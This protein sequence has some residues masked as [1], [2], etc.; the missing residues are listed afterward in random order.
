MILRPYQQDLF[1]EIQTELRSGV[2]APL[3]VS[4]TGSGKTA[5][6]CYIAHRAS[7][8]N[9]DVLILV[10]RAELIIQTSETLAR[11]G[12][13]HG[14]IQ[15]GISPA[16]QH[17]VQLGMVQTIARRLT[18]ITPP[19]LIIVDE[20]H[21]SAASQYK[22]IRAAFPCAVAIGFT[23]TPLRLDG[24]GLKDH[25]SKI[26]QG[27]TVEWLIQNGFLCRPKYYAPP[28][29]ADFSR[30]RTKMG[31]YI[32]SELA[33]EMS[34]PQITGD[35]IA[36]YRK[37]CPDARA[38]AFCC[39]LNHAEQVCAEFNDAGIASGLIS[40]SMDKQSRKQLVQDFSDNKIKVMVSVDVISEGFDIPAVETAILL[41]KT[42]SLGLYLQQI[43][44]ILRPAEG[45]QAVV[46]DHVGNIATHGLAEDEREWTLEGVD[47]K[48]GASK[49]AAQTIQC[50]QC[51]LVYSRKD[52]F[53]PG[54]GWSPSTKEIRVSDGE[55][56]E[57]TQITQIKTRPLRELLNQVKT[58]ED[59]KR[60]AKI[61]GY[62]KG[63]VWHI[64]KELNL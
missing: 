18:K 2:R 23:A 8:A 6:F 49:E 42:K 53:C 3:V 51:W 24:I 58:R 37:I 44:R 16:P 31:D 41:R 52:Y 54:C 43:G 62:K 21:H 46:L 27:K 25:F 30:V 45:K 11:Y 28:C 40:G 13:S 17:R 7:Q 9:N 63:W 32:S 26:I 48:Q 57:V 34:R 10:H 36:H 55:L 56:E 64:S 1:A 5:L 4:P 15:P 14:I 29:L 60:I 22:S 12:V 20:A 59:L 35:V 38:V 39:T 47:K 33:N 61:K 19:K 50:K